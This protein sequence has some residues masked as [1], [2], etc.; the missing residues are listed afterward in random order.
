MLNIKQHSR[1]LRFALEVV[2]SRWF[3]AFLVDSRRLYVRDSGKILK[4][5]QRKQFVPE[6]GEKNN[7]Y[8]SQQ[9][10]RAVEGKKK[11]YWGLGMRETGRVEVT[12]KKGKKMDQKQREKGLREREGGDEREIEVDRKEGTEKVG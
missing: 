6:E 12:W 2:A 7:N 10:R 1:N 11:T 5:W 4:P 8:Y 3:S 9:S